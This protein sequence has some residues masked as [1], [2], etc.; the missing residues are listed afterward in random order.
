MKKRYEDNLLAFARG[1]LPAEERA[2]MDTYLSEHPDDLAD[3]M[4]MKDLFY[5]VNQKAIDSK[6]EHDDGL[7][8]LRE[9]IFG[10][11]SSGDEGRKPATQLQGP[12]PQEVEPPNNEDEPH[13]NG[14]RSRKR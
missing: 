3:A 1:E 6:R 4:F 11:N 8:E 2:W 12:S 9:R 5:V 13:S 10:R 14:R 7:K